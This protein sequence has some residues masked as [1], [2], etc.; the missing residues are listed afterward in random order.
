MDRRS[1][2]HRQAELVVRVL[3]YIARRDEFALKGGAAINL[4]LRNL[5]V[6]R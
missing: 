2:F 6:C 4:F 1:P 5:P 3:P